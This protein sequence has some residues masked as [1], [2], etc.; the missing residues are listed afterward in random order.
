MPS[1]G[2][3]AKPPKI[4]V[5]TIIVNRG[6]STA[7]EAPI[8]VCLYRIFI[9]RNAKKNNSSLYCSISCISIEKKPFFG[10]I[11]SSYSFLLLV[12]FHTKHT[13]I[14]Y[15][16]GIQYYRQHPLTSADHLITAALNLDSALYLYLIS[17]LLLHRTVPCQKI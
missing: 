16:R 12:I 6:C 4:N 1:E 14:S 11:I 8:M 7:H 3:F 10:F 2:I 15:E 5:N 13:L 9:C 17:S